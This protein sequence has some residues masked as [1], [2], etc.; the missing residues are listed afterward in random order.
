MHISG[1]Q[2]QWSL[3]LSSVP[4]K[5]HSAGNVHLPVNVSGEVLTIHSLINLSGRKHGMALIDNAEV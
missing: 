4:P 1:L 5:N 3:V 2:Q